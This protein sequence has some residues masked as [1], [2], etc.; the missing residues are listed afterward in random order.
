MDG[1]AADSL[2][3]EVH[4]ANAGHRPGVVEVE[5]LV[6]DPVARRLP[7]VQERLIYAVLGHELDGLRGQRLGLLRILGHFGLRKEGSD[8]GKLRV[9]LLGH[10][11][12]LVRS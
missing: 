9:L 1:L 2:G 6:R 10:C 8:L 11:V 12:L 3:D 5:V 4:E 7:V